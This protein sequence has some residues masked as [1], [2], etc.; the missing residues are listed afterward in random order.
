MSVIVTRGTNKKPVSSEALAGFFED[1]AEL[2]GYLFLG[3]PIIGT[4][5]GKYTIKP[6]RNPC[7]SKIL[8]VILRIIPRAF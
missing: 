8:V 3:Y 1:R 2:E 6:N 4:A 5:E 7:L